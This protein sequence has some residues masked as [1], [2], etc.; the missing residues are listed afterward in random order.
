MI[1]D[2]VQSTQMTQKAL[3]NQAQAAKSVSLELSLR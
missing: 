2:E 1:N 3:T